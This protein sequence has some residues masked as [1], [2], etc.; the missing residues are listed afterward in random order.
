MIHQQTTVRKTVLSSIYF[1]IGCVLPSMLH[2]QLPYMP[3]TNVSIPDQSIYFEAGGNG[4]VYSMNYDLRFEN[5]FGFRVGISGVPSGTTTDRNRNENSNWYNF[6]DTPFLF[7]VIMGNYFAGTETNSLEFGAGVVIGEIYDKE[8]WNR[9]E[10]TAATF[11]IGYRYMNRKKWYPTFK[12]GLTPMVTF[13]GQA[14]MRVGIS[15]G[16]MISGDE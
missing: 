6:R 3:E 2:A 13:D 16:L 14:Y 5:N 10:P 1:V 4:I 9:P 15:I 7:S 8:R 12:A 11:T